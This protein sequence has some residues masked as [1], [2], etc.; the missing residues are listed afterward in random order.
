MMLA[1]SLRS[2]A[3]TSWSPARSISR[4]LDASHFVAD[5]IGPTDAAQVFWFNTAD[6]TL[7][8]DA[9]GNGVG[10]AIAIAVLDNGFVLDHT[11]LV[12]V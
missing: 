6:N 3:M 10:S 9:D 4:P 11:D 8:Y 1:V 2:A 5:D 7:Y 12:L